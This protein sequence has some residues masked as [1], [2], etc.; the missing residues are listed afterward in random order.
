MTTE[1]RLIDIGA[2][3][4]HE[5]FSADL[6]EVLSNAKSAGLEKIVLTG[7][8]VES[9]CQALNLAKQF[10]DFLYSTAGIH[11]HDAKL[12]D[13]EACLAL[14]NLAEHSSVKAIGETGLDFNRDFSPRPQQERAF[15]EQLALA[16]KLNMPV[17]LHQRDAHK[18]FYPILKEQLD[19]LPRA[20]VHCFTG[21]Q[22]EL[23]AYLDLDLYIG[24]T[25]WICDERRGQNLHAIIKD[26]P[27]NRLM[28]ETDAPYLLPRTIKPK[29]KSR[30]NEP[31]NLIYV[32][33]TVARCL[34]RSPDLVAKQT[35]QNARDFFDL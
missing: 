19:Q 9:S 25:G 10:P 4:S 26:I 8:C 18:R 30:R 13:S 27:A 33:E 31:A 16:A 34:D 14:E 23:Y 12:F 1:C 6:E 35:N 22:E 11:P 7:T 2:N 29:P 32:L 17:F 15:A 3:L 28:L 24:I 20:V 5:S 21:D